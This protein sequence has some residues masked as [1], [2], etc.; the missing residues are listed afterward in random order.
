MK[1][2]L[3]KMGIP[4]CSAVVGIVWVF[5]GL[6]HHGF[7]DEI[8]GPL[9]GFVPSLMAGVMVVVS[10]VGIFQSL[11]RE[12]APGRRESWT[13]LLAAFI[14]FG[15]VFLVGMIP[16]L[17]VFVFLWLRFYEKVSWKNTIIILVISFGIAYG[18]FVEWLSIPF[19][20]GVIIDAILW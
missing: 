17:L 8:K 1:A 6:T 10:I 20:N 16:A 7:W 5:V 19:P 15:L 3:K 9:P 12:D 18:V 14:T 13:I 11:K 4:L 2:S